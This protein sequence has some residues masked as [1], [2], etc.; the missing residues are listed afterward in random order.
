[1]LLVDQPS[2]V[3]K[4][5]ASACCVLGAKTALNRNGKW[6][7]HGKYASAD[8]IYKMQPVMIN[9]YLRNK[10]DKFQSKVGGLKQELISDL[11]VL[12]F[13]FGAGG[14]GG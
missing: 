11:E 2:H 9:A 4:T 13:Y 1:L 12:W 14:R 3:K 10:Y 6:T 5:S 8:A 7:K